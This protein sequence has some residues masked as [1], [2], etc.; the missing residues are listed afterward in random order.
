MLTH[1]MEK[2]MF[3]TPSQDYLIIISQSFSDVN[4]DSQF[5]RNLHSNPKI[6]LLF[7]P[8]SFWERIDKRASQGYNQVIAYRRCCYDA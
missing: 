4:K 3:A 6:V 1:R 7:L 5:L 8:F 2:T